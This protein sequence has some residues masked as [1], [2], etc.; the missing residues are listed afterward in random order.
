MQYWAV[1]FKGSPYLYQMKKILLIIFFIGFSIGL[2]GLIKTLMAKHLNFSAYDT[3]YITGE[4]LLMIIF[5][6]LSFFLYRNIRANKN[7]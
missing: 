3:G 6:L 4:I 5:G 7:T 1:C 2:F